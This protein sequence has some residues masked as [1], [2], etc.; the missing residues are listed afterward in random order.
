MLSKSVRN[1]AELIYRA[2]ENGF[3]AKDFHDRCDDVGPTLIICQRFYD[4]NPDDDE[5]E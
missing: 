3:G 1:Q 2:S 5:Y 4:P